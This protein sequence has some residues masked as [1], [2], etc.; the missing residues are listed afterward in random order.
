M[1]AGLPGQRN[2]SW[3]FAFLA[4]ISSCGE[5]VPSAE[6]RPD[7]TASPAEPDPN[8]GPIGPLPQPAPTEAQPPAP[9]VEPSV[10]DA[11]SVAADP[12]TDP[13]L[14]SGVRLPLLG[15]T[16]LV[17]R[18]DS[19]AVVAEPLANVVYVVDLQSL[20]LS[21]TVSLP[22]RAMPTRLVEDDAGAMHVVLRGTDQL[23]TLMPSDG[24]WSTTEICREP[25]GVAFVPGAATV[26]VACRSG[27]VLWFDAEQLRGGPAEP[28]QSVQLDADLRDV[29]SL[30]DSLWISKF[31]SA[32]LI[33]LSSSGEVLSQSRPSTV[34]S[35]NGIGV[36]EPRVAHRLVSTADGSAY[37]LHQRANRAP[38]SSTYRSSSDC[39]GLTHNA[40]TALPN[41]ATGASFRSLGTQ[42]H[43]GVPLDMNVSA[44]GAQL[45]T[46]SW[47]G[48]TTQLAVSSLN[49]AAASPCA[50]LPAELQELD[51]LTTS[52][53]F[54]GAGN[55]LLLAPFSG[56][57][58]VGDA[59]VQL[60]NAPT[61]DS[62][63]L[64]FYQSTQRGMACA[65]CHPEG[66]DDGM[67]WTFSVDG[68]R[69]TQPVAGRISSTAPLHWK[70]DRADLTELMQ[71]TFVSRMGGQLPGAEQIAALQRYLDSL[72]TSKPPVPS[73]DEEAQLGRQHFERLLCDSCHQ[74]PL[75]TD[76]QNHDVGSGDSF[77]TPSL[78]GLA[79]RLP[80][81]H[82]GC[83]DTLTER[84]GPCGGDARHGDWQ[85]LS[86]VEL[87]QLLRY[88]ES[89]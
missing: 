30:G 82:D 44:D 40:I 45:A 56:T 7:D 75:L 15:G 36:L 60:P 19:F 11:P 69:R 79:Y 8:F 22:E 25:R 78:L 18:D 62:G 35:M 14:Q 31:R 80:L 42:S 6:S 2:I 43:S 54:D 49:D 63:M 1:S 77:Q 24:Q 21:H 34:T 41:T 32:E 46:L 64:L 71:D 33:E 37:V 9:S 73:D 59:E 13:E 50:P 38:N 68:K 76:N 66:E 23:M 29:A 51:A 16:L 70:G 39:E 47:N 27:E 20:S 86:E 72:P 53:A 61:L 83:A 55:L 48:E 52:V 5:L 12:G 65:S 17:T 74:G 28:T 67:T 3:I 84:F 57:L 26:V 10:G 81:M 87:S 4:L 89:L 58:W 85:S 88:L